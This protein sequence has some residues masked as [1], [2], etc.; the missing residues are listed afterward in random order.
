MFLGVVCSM[1]GR[2]RCILDG[3]GISVQRILVWILISHNS[4]RLMAIDAH[5]GFICGLV[6]SSA[7]RHMQPD[8]A[9]HGL[10]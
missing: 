2:R 7:I 4:S 5:V 8:A 9:V 1:Q 3:V 10:V 6:Y